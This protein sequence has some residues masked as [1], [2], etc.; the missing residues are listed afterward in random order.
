[1]ELRDFSSS[2]N[3]CCFSGGD[4][5]VLFCWICKV[6]LIAKWISKVE[7]SLSL[8]EWINVFLNKSC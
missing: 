6:R 8:I 2:G 4:S 7:E 1:M 5:S 3:C